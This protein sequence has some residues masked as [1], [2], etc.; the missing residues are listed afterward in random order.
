MENADK[1][2]LLE[3]RIN[4]FVTTSNLEEP[5]IVPIMSQINSYA[6]AYCGKTA[7][8]AFEDPELERQCYRLSLIHI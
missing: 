6:I 1:K 3:K 5:D 4:R 2:Q 8:D 7:W